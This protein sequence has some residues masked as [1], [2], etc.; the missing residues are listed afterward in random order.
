M[1]GNKKR[2]ERLEKAAASPAGFWPAA[3]RRFW[4]NRPARWA[5]RLLFVLLFF[6]LFADFLANEKPLY[7]RIAGETHFPVFQQYAVDLGLAQWDARFVNQ[8]WKDQP[9]EQVIWP[10]I[11]YSARTID[12]RNMNYVSPFD[13]QNVDSRRFRHWL[14]TDQ[15]GRDVAAGMITGAR[16]AILVGVVA[17]SV[18]ALIGIL[19]GTLAGFFG[20]ERLRVSRIGLILQVVALMLGIFYGFIVRQYAIAQG[21]FGWEVL[22]SLGLVLGFLLAGYALAI[23]LRRLP[24][25]G[26]PVVL[27]MDLLVMRAIEV[28]NSIPS[29]LLI[30][31][32]VAVIERSNI[33]HVM[34]IIGLISWTS[35][36]RFTRAELLRIRG[37]TYIE[38]ARAL[39]VREWRIILRHA[40]PNAITPVMITIA[41]GIANAILLEATLTFLS[42]E[43]AAEQVTWGKLLNLA[44]GYAPAWW[45]AVFPGL[46]IFFSVTLFNLIGEGLTDALDPR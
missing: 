35:I 34:L 21:A 32:I 30:L 26:R 22:K 25:L 19:L 39:G 27:P 9:Y 31:S 43:V 18:A 4:R 13:D 37:L 45:L 24:V 28:V 10:P 44:R 36:A 7:A 3:R 16:T 12:R 38:A 6:A 8:S 2:I 15:I 40:L 1:L 14:G 20:D 5:L 23:P 42:V 46:A 41:F 29:L 17:M 33:L 11:P